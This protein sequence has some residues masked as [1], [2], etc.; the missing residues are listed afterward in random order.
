MASWGNHEKILYLFPRV[1]IIITI[2]YEM[3]QKLSLRLLIF[4]ISKEIQE[5]YV[6]FYSFI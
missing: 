4:T 2:S 3:H 5:K 1:R 6:L